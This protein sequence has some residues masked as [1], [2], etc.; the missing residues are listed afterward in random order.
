MHYLFA[1]LLLLLFTITIKG[2]ISIAINYLRIAEKNK[3]IS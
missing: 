3:I 1:D 2:N